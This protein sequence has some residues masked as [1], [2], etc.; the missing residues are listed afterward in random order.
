M[1]ARPPP[2]QAQGLRAGLQMTCLEAYQSAESKIGLFV[3]IAAAP[4]ADIC[5]A[6]PDEIYGII[7]S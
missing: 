5:R 2:S 6:C 4:I 3:S 7:A 1:Q